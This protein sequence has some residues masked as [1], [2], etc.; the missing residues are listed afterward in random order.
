MG[1]RVP[2]PPPDFGTDCPT[3][4]PG[5]WAVGKTPSVIYAYCSGFVPCPPVNSITANGVTFELPQV[6]GSPCQFESIGD[7]WK[8][9]LD[10]SYAGGSASFMQLSYDGNVHLRVNN[11]SPCPS[12][13]FRYANPVT[14]CFPG[15]LVYDGT[16]MIFWN[17]PYFPLVWAMGI[18]AV[19]QL[20]NE[21]FNHTDSDTVV[22]FTDLYSR[23]NLRVK[24]TP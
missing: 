8:I 18:D 17:L 11:A 3:C 13:F 19:N 10:V 23:T 9:E 5:L 2:C 21:M 1:T 15:N 14:Q 20:F 24:V 4:T 7:N 6:L 12:E 16:I 22:K